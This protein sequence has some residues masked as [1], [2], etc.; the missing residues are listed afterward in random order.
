[1][2]ILSPHLKLFEILP[3][4]KLAEFFNVKFL[5]PALY[6]IS[7]SSFHNVWQKKTLK[8]EVWIIQIMILSYE[9]MIIFMFLF[10]KL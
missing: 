1:M 3:L 6:K 4:N 7:P 8:N 10:L 2:H 5:H 9:M